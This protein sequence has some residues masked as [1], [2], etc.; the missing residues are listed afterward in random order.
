MGTIV[1]VDTGRPIRGA[2]FLALNP[3]VTFDEFESDDQ[4]YSAAEADRDGLFLLPDPLER[5][6]SYTLVAG[7]SGY[8]PVYEDDVYVG[9]N[10]DPIVDLTIKLKRR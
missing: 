5:G 3:G 4:I 1:D 2:I 8:Y 6:E 7:L 9:A 10:A